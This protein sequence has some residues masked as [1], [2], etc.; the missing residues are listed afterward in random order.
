MW[1]AH[2]GLAFGSRSHASWQV[3]G[4]SWLLARGGLRVL[5]VLGALGVLGVLGVLAW[6]LR[7]SKEQEA[8][9]NLSRTFL[10]CWHILKHSKRNVNKSTKNKPLEVPKPFQSL[11]RMFPE[12]SPCLK[13]RGWKLQILRKG[14]STTQPLSKM[15][16]K[17]RILSLA[18]HFEP[19]WLLRAPWGAQ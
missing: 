8:C 17:L 5:D 18:R 2:A 3:L 12:P 9:Q 19:S 1:Q 6:K 16:K 4:S 15:S 13:N 10:G 7:K 14:D 11:P